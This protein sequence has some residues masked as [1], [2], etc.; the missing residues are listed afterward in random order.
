MPTIP[1][2]QSESPT[3]HTNDV[4]PWVLAGLLFLIALVIGGGVLV[5]VNRQRI[6]V[7]RP[8]D[9]AENLLLAG[10]P[11]QAIRVLESQAET[12]YDSP[13]VAVR[14]AEAHVADQQPAEAIKTLEQAAERWPQDLS[15]RAALARLYAQSGRPLAALVQ[16]HILLALD[17]EDSENHLALADAHTA[18]GETKIA[19]QYALK[20]ADV[21]PTNAHAHAALAQAYA[22]QGKPKKCLA[23]Y[24]RACKLAPKNPDYALGRAEA[25]AL[26]KRHAVALQ[27][28]EQLIQP[29]KAAPHMLA[30]LAMAQ[31]KAGQAQA[32]AKT[33]KLVRK[34]H[35]NQALGLK[36]FGDVRR[37]L[38]DY[39]GAA[40]AYRKALELAPDLPSLH[41]ALA[42]TFLLAGS[43]PKAVASCNKALQAQPSNTEARNLLIAIHERNGDEAAIHYQRG[44]LHLAKGHMEAAQKALEKALDLG[45]KPSKIQLALA[46][47]YYEQGDIT[48]A[49][50]A[51]GVVRR[52]GA[53]TAETESLRGWLLL[54]KGEF[55]GAAQ[56]WR[57]ALRLASNHGEAYLGLA[58]LA[59]RQGDSGGALTSCDQALALL[60]HDARSRMRLAEVY[61]DIGEIQAA[62]DQYQLALDLDP[63]LAQAASELA[64]L[65]TADRWRLPEAVVLARRAA[66]LAPTDADAWD[67]LGWALYHQQDFAEADKALDRALAGRPA[68]PDAL[69]HKAMICLA[70][71]HT[72]QAR[73]LL[74]RSLTSPLPFTQRKEAEAA[75]EDFRSR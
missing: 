53:Q 30:K 61:A 18:L 68:M 57:K 62:V 13:L 72:D 4:P 34:A 10:N 52:R 47:V 12:R 49:Q 14:L 29:D 43:Y 64:A 26:L 42:R 55:P 65:Y 50:K 51:L 1:G 17:A 36:V 20:I 44:L 67:V 21:H 39:E 73:A 71:D 63:M 22:K 48:Q 32:A 59:K 24:E 8:L 35:P 70:Q 3:P 45:A 6:L 11:S 60:G 31:A 7:Q 54:E 38:A 15:L 56:A 5:L 58:E 41:A 25:L 23:A 66:R 16:R 9:V 37:E 27:Q 75:L 69:Y 46:R 19:L 40:Q 2:N 74:E 28:L 33:A